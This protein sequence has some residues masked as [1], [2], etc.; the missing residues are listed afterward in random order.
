MALRI[1]TFSHLKAGMWEEASESAQRLYAANYLKPRNMII[2]AFSLMK[3]E[4]YEEA[5]G[6]LR[7]M[8]KRQ[9]N[10]SKAHYFIGVAMSKLHKYQRAEW[11]LKRAAQLAPK[12]ISIPFFLVENS[13]KAGDQ[14]GVERHL[15]RLFLD[16]SIKN[17]ATL[18]EGIPDDALKVGFTPELLAPL[19]ADR[20]K[21]KTHEFE[22]MAKNQSG[23]SQSED[24]TVGQLNLM[25][26]EDWLQK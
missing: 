8:L 23:Q 3:V 9:P 21:A 17:I 15:D 14:A 24:N 25:A 7:E 16:H 18:A 4:K 12:D 5:L 2:L 19:I 20:I 26:H 10:D 6:Y 11:F 22:Q 13:L 1:L